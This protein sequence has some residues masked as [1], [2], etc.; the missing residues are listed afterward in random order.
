MATATASALLVDAARLPIYLLSA[1]PVI[2]GSVDLWVA[3]SIGVTVGTF[4][5]VPV[6][7]RIPEGAYRR[8]LGG[9]L[10]LLGLALLATAR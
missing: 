1:G 6:L 8:F 7:G 10:V 2:A 9:V 3:A 5:G 4:L